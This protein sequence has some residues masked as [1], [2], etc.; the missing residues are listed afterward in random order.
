M[1]RRFVNDV[2]SKEF[3]QSGKGTTA[4]VTGCL[5][6]LDSVPVIIDETYNAVPELRV[7]ANL[8]GELNRALVCTN[9]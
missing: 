9:N 7:L 8:F 1:N 2:V 3:S 5:K 6:L 4:G